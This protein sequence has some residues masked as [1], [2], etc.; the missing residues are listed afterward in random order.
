MKKIGYWLVKSWPTNLLLAASVGIRIYIFKVMHPIIHTDSITFLFLREVDMVRTPGYPLFIEFMFFI[1]DF[2]HLTSD[3]MRWL[4]FGQLFILGVLNAYLIYKIARY[5]TKNRWFALAMGMIYNLNFFV[6]GFELQVMTETLSITLLLA[7]MIPVFQIFKGKK[8]LAVG[9]GLLMVLLLYTRATFL[10]LGAGLPVLTVMVYF[11]QFKKHDF[12][13]KY[14]TAIILFLAVN[15]L[16]I[17]AWSLR[18][19]IKYGYFGV[20][21]LMPYQLRYYTNDLFVEYKPSG[22]A[23]LDRV[24]RIYAEEFEKKGHSSATVFNFHTRLNQEMG[25]S[26]AEISSAFMRVNLKLIRDYPGEYLKQIPDSVLSYY[27]QYSPYWTAGNT[28]KF[29]QQRDIISIL[30]RNVL[31]FYRFLFTRSIPLIWLMLVTPVL[32][33]LGSF[34]QR[35]SFFGWLVL[36]A[37]IHYNCFVSAFS[38]N[39]GIN[40]LP[41]RQPVEPLILLMFFAGFFYLGKAL[42]KLY[43]SRIEV[44]VDGRHSG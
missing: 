24:A 28:R 38:T 5:L 36:L 43:Y 41:Y 37:I 11:S 22:D 25:L 27:R 17:G 12:R 1:N 14:G 21:S 30:F 6:V 35:E 3:F 9:T 18:N 8:N 15:L 4:C 33:L 32:V 44:G 20:S 19:K 23:R 13:K 10:L 29:I 34:K 31:R 7:V 39:A 40:N 2:F 26:D 42:V 16:G